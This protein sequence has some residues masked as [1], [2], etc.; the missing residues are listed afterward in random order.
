MTLDPHTLSVGE[1]TLAVAACDRAGNVQTAQVKFTVEDN[2]P[3]VT[4][5]A[6]TDGD[7]VSATSANLTV[8]GG[9]SPAHV[10]FRQVAPFLLMKSSQL[11]RTK[12]PQRTARSLLSCSR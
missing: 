6:D 10:S 11:P 12:R 2:D 4:L 5:D 1:H 9:E 3:D 7:G 8:N